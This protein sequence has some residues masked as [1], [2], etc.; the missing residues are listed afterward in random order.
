MNCV[1]DSGSAVEC[2]QADEIGGECDY[3][4]IIGVDVPNGARLS[5][6]GSHG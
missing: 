4:M 3:A 1:D 6:N 2:V 5:D